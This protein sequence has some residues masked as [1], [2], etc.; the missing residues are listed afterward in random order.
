MQYRKNL[1]ASFGSQI[2][3]VLVNVITVPIYISILGAEAFGLISFYAL[4]QTC[5]QLLDVGMT[6]SVTRKMALASNSNSDNGIFVAYFRMLQKVFIAVSLLSVVTFFFYSK[7][8]TNSW[9]SA[10]EIKSSEIMISLDLMFITSAVRWYSGLYRGLITGL[11]KIVWLGS[12]TVA[13]TAIRT[14]G[15]LAVVFF[16]QGGLV[17]FFVLQFLCAVLELTYLY[18][19]SF[20]LY[21]TLSE[22]TYDK[23]IKLN[24]LSDIKLAAGVSFTSLIWVAVSQMDKFILSGMLNLKEYGYFNAAM[25][26][27]GGITIITSSFCTVLLPKL[28]KIIGLNSNEDLEIIYSQYTRLIVT[29]ACPIMC[30]FLFFSQELLFGWTGN[31]ELAKMSFQAL[32]LYSVGNFILSLSVLIYYVQLAKGNLKYHI[33]GNVLFLVTFIPMLYLLVRAYGIRGAGI[34]WLIVNVLYFFI[35]ANFSHNKMLSFKFYDWIVKNLIPILIPCFIVAT[36][37]RLFIE[38]SASRLT[39]IIDV[40]LVGITLMATSVL[41][42]REAT[43]YVKS[44]FNFG[45]SNVK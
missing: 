4:I 17:M 11:E 7:T 28:T 23:L 9:L 40:L 42:T 25:T 29:I 21:P 10:T 6:A 30:C 1:I 39:N 34:A 36:F 33:V 27:A 43:N 5:F 24:F 14:L 15:I 38:H 35:W 16:A 19:F 3:V 44:F 37:L 26:A 32:A 12:F 20:V 31:L 13:S 2:F 22:P 18:F 45:R 41:A 8:I